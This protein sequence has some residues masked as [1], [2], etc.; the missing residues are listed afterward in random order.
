MAT[1]S[2]AQ[3]FDP[4]MVARLEATGWKAYYDHAWLRAFLLLVRLKSGA[5]SYSV[6]ALPGGRL[7]YRAGVGGLR[8][9]R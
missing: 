3:G 9:P 1:H 6:S 4:D 2:L 8:P 7:L 5:V